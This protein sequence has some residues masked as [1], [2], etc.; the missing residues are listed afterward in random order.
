MYIPDL[1]GAYVKGRELAIDKNWQDLKNFEAVE[2]ARNQNDLNAMDI[3]E[4][5]QQMPGK[6]NMF[7]NQVHAS[8]LAMQL[9]NAAQR[10]RLAQANM[11]ADVAVGRYGVFDKYKQDYFNTLG[12]NFAAAL[13][14]QANTAQAKFGAN[15]YLKDRA[16]NLGK[17]NAMIGENQTLANYETSKNLTNAAKQ[18]TV[19]SNQAFDN[20]FEAGRLQERRLATA[21]DQQDIIA[22]NADYALGNVIPD[23]E[24]RRAEKEG[25]QAVSDA[26]LAELYGLA[27]NKVPSAVARLEMLKKLPDGT[28]QSMFGISLDHSQDLLAPSQA[29]STS[30]V[31]NLPVYD[32][33]VRA[34]IGTYRPTIP[35]TQQSRVLMQAPTAKPVAPILPT[36]TP[37]QVI[38]PKAVGRILPSPK[39]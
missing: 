1:F 3:W 28:F 10:G 35:L 31:P 9:M 25:V 20:N 36:T 16:Y 38:V 23:D 32:Y 14:Q 17:T 34:D 33:P 29:G 5:R 18:S 15:D 22:K 4:R 7:Y 26:E 24:A 30:P 12:A 13:G 39:L 11:G 37:A 27:S 6:T 8:N 19:L 2:A 21:I